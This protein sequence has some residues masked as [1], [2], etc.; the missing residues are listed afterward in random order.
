MLGSITKFFFNK[1][2]VLYNRHR[3]TLPIVHNA[4]NK[5]DFLFFE[6]GRLWRFIPVKSDN[7]WKFRCMYL[8]LSAIGPKYILDINWI[9]SGHR[10]YDLWCRRNPGSRFVVVQHGS[11]VGG[12]VT[13]I[14]HRYAHCQVFLCW[15]DYFGDLFGRYNEGK[16]TDIRVF[17]NPVYNL[18]DRS[19]YQY[20]K[21][22]GNRILLAPSGVKAERLVQ[23]TAF[24][25]RLEALGFVVD[26]KE[27]NFQTRKFEE[28]KGFN[29]ISGDIYDILR[30]H[31]YDIVVSDHSSCLLDAIFFKN[32][33]L[34]FSPESDMR[35]YYDN[36]YR[37]YLVNAASLLDQITSREALFD[38]LD[39]SAQE[40]LFSHFVAAGDNRLTGIK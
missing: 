27:H 39:T 28:I 12:I 4:S 20:R 30:T 40:Q 11:Y 37:R 24:K 34:F 35:A 14:P 21:P 36:L 26:L 17:G 10:L 2:I 18:T 38:L 9:S 31:A 33:V 13:D 6:I 25:D 16:P 5:S 15:S 1:E 32:H 22:S 3:Q 19:P 7:K 29:K 8:L 23:L